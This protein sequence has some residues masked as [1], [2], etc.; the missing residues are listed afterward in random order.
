MLPSNQTPKCP[1]FVIT[2][3]LLVILLSPLPHSPSYSV[4]S[5]VSYPAS[6]RANHSP[7]YSV[8]NP[9]SYLD[10]YLASYGAGYPPE[11]P[12]S[13]WENCGEGSSPDCSADGSEN[14]SG[15][16]PESNRESNGANCSE[17]YSVDSLPGCLESYP[18][19]SD[20]RPVTE[21]AQVRRPDRPADWQ[22]PKHHHRVPESRRDNGAQFSGQGSTC[23]G[24]H[25]A[26]S[27]QTSTKP[28]SAAWRN[29]FSVRVHGSE[30]AHRGVWLKA[31][32]FVTRLA[33]LSSSVCV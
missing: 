3:W 26:T 16:N 12:A 27:S 31:H 1:N 32:Y 9:V 14:R 2:N 28:S 30:S 13:Y 11:N 22:L 6:N 24:N 23:R 21:P 15:S 4:R 7:S 20:P 8:R 10:G 18:E 25:A 17:S 5:W 19:N 29:R 33:T